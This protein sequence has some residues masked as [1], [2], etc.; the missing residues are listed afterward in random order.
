MA[1]PSSEITTR[2]SEEVKISKET[3]KKKKTFPIPEG[4]V[5]AHGTLAALRD[6]DS[7]EFVVFEKQSLFNVDETS[8]KKEDVEKTESREREGV[9]ETKERKE[10][11]AP[12]S[13]ETSTEQKKTEEKR[14]LLRILLCRQDKYDVKL[15]ENGQRTSIKLA[16]RPLTLYFLFGNP[17]IR[18]TPDLYDGKV[19][20]GFCNSNHE[21]SVLYKSSY[22]FGHVVTWHDFQHFEIREYLKKPGN[23]ATQQFLGINPEPVRNALLKSF[24]KVL[25]SQRIMS[26]EEVN[27]FQS[28]LPS[29]PMPKD[30]K[31]LRK[32]IAKLF[33]EYDNTENESDGRI[34]SAQKSILE[35]IL[36]KTEKI[37]KDPLEKAVEK[38][39]PHSIGNTVPGIFRL[40]FLDDARAALDVGNA[41]LKKPGLEHYALR[42]FEIVG[43]YHDHDR[44]FVYDK[45]DTFF[46]S[47]YMKLIREKIADLRLTMSG[48]GDS[49]EEIK[50]NREKAAF[51][52]FHKIEIDPTDVFEEKF[53][54]FTKFLNCIAGFDAVGQSFLPEQQK[55]E[56]P[57]NIFL[58]T[59][60]TLAH[61]V[62][63][64]SKLIAKL[65]EKD[66][67]EV[68]Q[69]FLESQKKSE[70]S[71]P[72]SHPPIIF[73]KKV[74][75]K[76][77]VKAGA[78]LVLSESAKPKKES[79]GSLDSDDEDESMASKKK[80]QGTGKG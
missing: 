80:L 10:A 14:L 79:S 42:A 12:L 21:Y 33:Q 26:K 55:G 63:D 3:H 50:K 58:K 37:H 57:T 41:F 2:T 8:E 1:T 18:N 45:P 69:E 25:I 54:V 9:R 75:R 62:A 5:L 76:T 13:F 19:N 77:A 44:N 70:A 11:D 73:S 61:R 35:A 30:E 34:S 78:G 16:K 59:C 53:R 60:L 74:D 38:G 22:N 36:A 7:K 15:L 71:S 27:Y 47:P 31:V 29:K 4:W 6:N 67:I 28:I 49:D 52:L 56:L 72:S 20:D 17:N 66:P 43:N 51:S 68:M 46:Q 48:L 32:S 39:E 24:F 64:Q 65:T 23:V 40:F